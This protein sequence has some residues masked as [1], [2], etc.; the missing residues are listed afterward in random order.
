MNVTNAW[1]LTALFSTCTFFLFHIYILAEHDLDILESNLELIRMSR[2]GIHMQKPNRRF[3]S[4]RKQTKWSFKHLNHTTNLSSQGKDPTNHTVFNHSVGDVRKTRIFPTVKRLE[5]CHKC[6]V[7]DFKTIIPARNVCSYT[8]PIELLILITS[9]PW[10]IVERN[11][12]RETWAS[13]TKNNTSPLF[14]HVFLFGT[15]WNKSEQSI[16][17]RESLQF[18]DILQESYVDTY[19]N[20]SY[21]VLSGFKWAQ[22]QC[23]GAKHIMRTADDNFINLPKVLGLITYKITHASAVIGYVYRAMPP[24]RDT[25]SKH[26]VSFLEWPEGVNYPPYCEGTAFLMSKTVAELLLNTSADVPYF[27]LED[28]YIGMVMKRAGIAAKAAPG[29]SALFDSWWMCESYYSIHPV[30]PKWMRTIWTF[31]QSRALRALTQRKHKRR[32]QRTKT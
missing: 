13:Y 9:V 1:K 7:V 19:Y 31:C 16:L 20:L 18:G 21:K 28:V 17:K 29:F 24:E 32:R 8:K 14:R 11:T 4:H 10:N 6:F 15:G 3:S 26:R 2:D 22:I 12:V 30:T 27:P 25:A 5:S 23:F